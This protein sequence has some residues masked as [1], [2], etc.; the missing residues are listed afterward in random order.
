MPAGG[1][2]EVVAEQRGDQEMIWTLG[3]GHSKS[4]AEHQ[5][6]QLLSA[7]RKLLGLPEGVQN[8]VF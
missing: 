2:G 6:E 8:T 5:R 3:Q 4:E 7:T 1:R